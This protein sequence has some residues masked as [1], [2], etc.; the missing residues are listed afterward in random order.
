LLGPVHA[1]A[2]RKRNCTVERAEIERRFGA[3]T[4]DKFAK[5]EAAYHGC[6]RITRKVEL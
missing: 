4:E 1:E 6:R 2:G 5:A 3:I